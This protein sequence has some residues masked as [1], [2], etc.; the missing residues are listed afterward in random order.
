MEHFNVGVIGSGPAGLSAAFPLQAA[1]QSVVI[2][3][4]YLNHGANFEAKDANPRGFAI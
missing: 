2:V 3:E 1:G 4:E